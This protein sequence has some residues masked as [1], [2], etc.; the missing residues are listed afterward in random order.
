MEQCLACI[1]LRFHASRVNNCFSHGQLSAPDF[2][3]A[4]G[5]IGESIGRH[6]QC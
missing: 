6:P 4:V 3:M 2:G 5:G 1:S